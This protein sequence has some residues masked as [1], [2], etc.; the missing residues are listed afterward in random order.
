MKT[1]ILVLLS[2]VIVQA[3]HI[4]WYSNYDR[5]HQTALKEQKL[6]MVLLIEEECPQCY[7]MLS[8]T[9]MNQTYIKE[10]NETFVS[11]VVTKGQK[12]SYPIE[13]LYTMRYPSLF[14][15]NNQ[16]LFIGENIYGYADP[17]AF[18]RHLKLENFFD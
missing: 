17:D 6:L 3:E 14:F 1:V 13:M 7:K 10:I 2:L 18:E 4:R 16:E 11:V 5:A 9:F 8:T 12:E 15:L